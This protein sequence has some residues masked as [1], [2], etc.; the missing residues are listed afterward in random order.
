MHEKFRLWKIIGWVIP[1][2]K[3]SIKTKEEFSEERKQKVKQLIEQGILKSRPLVEAMLKVPREE[4]IQE[5]YKDYAYFGKD[6]WHEVPLPIPGEEATISCPHSY[7]LFYEALGLKENDYFLEVGT[8]SGYGA[9]LAR[10]VVGD[11]GKV[12]T[13]E[14]DK[15]TYEFAQKNIKRLG[16]NDI[17]LVHGDGGFGYEKEAPYDKICITAACSKIPEPLFLQLK[18]GGRLIAPVLENNSF[19]ELILFE[20]DQYG[21]LRKEFFGKVLYV[22]LRGKY[23]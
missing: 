8:G 19:Q 22:V 16:Y 14:I 13:I 2:P 21:K 7:P 20:K 9:V 23:G 15:I 3:K 4:F 18:K 1:P 5:M 10:E 6:I 11:N 12:V 17:L